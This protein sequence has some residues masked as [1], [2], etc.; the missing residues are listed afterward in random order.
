[1][2]KLKWLEELFWYGVKNA[3][4]E[5]IIK[6]KIICDSNNLCVENVKVNLKSYRRIFV[7]GA[8][9]ASSLMGKG[10]EEIL[11]DRIEGGIIVTKD[12]HALSLSWIETREA[13]HPLPDERGK[14]SAEDILNLAKSLGEKD[15]LIVLLSGGGSALLPLPAKGISLQEKQE[16]TNALMERGANIEELNIVRKHIS[17]IKGGWLAYYAHPARVV[18]LSISD[19]VGNSPSLIAS[20]PTVPDPSTFQE[21]KDVL[22]KKRLWKTLPESVRKHLNRGIEGKIPET[23]KGKEKFW[24]NTSYHLLLTNHE[25]LEW[26]KEKAE[27]NVPA[28]ILTSTLQGEAREIARFYA[29]LARE[30]RE[31]AQPFSPPVLLIAGGEPTV[32]V[33]GKG[34]GGRNQEL[35]LSFAIEAKGI[36]DV[37]FL[38]AGT[39]GTDGPTDAAGAWASGE[40]Y[41]RAKEKN[42][43]PERFLEENNSYVFFN[44]LHS[45]FF[46]GPTGTNVMDV[47]LLYIF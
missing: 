44:K 22:V 43:S 26:I 1:M 7:V 30:I 5:S 24:K 28:Y 37:L 46:T 8:G 14:N 40:T 45:L 41:E 32:K 47:H 2:S 21:A 13:S 4:P 10:V 42:I 39:D 3:N 35:V 15:V 12:S 9:K 29:S 16:I 19:V 11:G 25:V 36:P 33:K 18:T 27:E 23:P 31:H 17:Q 34:K 20:G 6:K 38:A